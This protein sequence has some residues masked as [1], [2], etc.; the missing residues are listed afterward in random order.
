MY[1]KSSAIDNCW[2]TPS[3]VC[4]NTAHQRYNTPD[5]Y[6]DNGLTL[7]ETTP[8]APLGRMAVGMALSR[9][10]LRLL[11]L[12]AAIACATLLYNLAIAPVGEGVL[13]ASSWADRRTAGSS[14]IFGEA[15]PNGVVWDTPS[16]HD[17]AGGVDS[18]SDRSGSFWQNP[19]RSTPRRPA[20]P[21]SYR[22]ST[23]RPLPRV[24]TTL[25]TRNNIGVSRV[26]K[27]NTNPEEYDEGPLP[28]LDEAFRHLEPVLRA[29]KERHQNIPREHQL[30]EPIFPPFLTDD[31]QERFWHLREEWDPSTKTWKHSGDRRFLLVTICRQ[32]A[33]ESSHSLQPL[34]VQKLMWC[35]HA[36]RLVRYVDGVGRLPRSRDTSLLSPRGRFGGRQV[37]VT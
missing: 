1:F 34:F 7:S 32:V 19:F 14:S 11:Y 8:L 27:P 15:N 30:W 23:P 36:S 12:I 21:P 33:G 29:V 9:P 25:A 26:A 31:L 35:R 16:S 20:K 28:N 4:S 13:D 17:A 5:H 2:S 22:D 10:V 24:N 18:D 37:S 6:P 3:D